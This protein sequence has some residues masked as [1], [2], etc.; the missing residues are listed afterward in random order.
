MMVGMTTENNDLQVEKK[1]IEKYIK[2]KDFI[3]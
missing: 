3:N 1:K 2:K